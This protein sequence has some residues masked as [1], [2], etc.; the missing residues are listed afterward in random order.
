MEEW[1]KLDLNG[2]EIYVSNKGRAK[3]IKPNGEWFFYKEGISV[4]G[5]VNVAGRKAHVLVA[6][7]FLNHQPCGHNLVVS[8]IDGNKLNN[9]LDNLE[10]VTQSQ[11]ILRK[12]L[13]KSSIYNF[14]SFDDL[15]KRY[16]VMMKFEGKYRYFGSF[17]NEDDAGDL[18]N[19][20]S[21]KYRIEDYR[22]NE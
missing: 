19:Y 14:V 8:H 11:N 20:L 1:R 21:N 13:P 4:D 12:D 5:Y 18:A 6:M 16:K 9:N 17:S 2:N 15:T 22:V 7:A 3:R 10:V